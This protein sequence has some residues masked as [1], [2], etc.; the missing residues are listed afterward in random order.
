MER[1][2]DNLLMKKLDA[3]TIQKKGV[4]S[5]VLM[6]RAALAVTEELKKNFILDSVLVVCG[7]GNNGGDGLA[8][9]RLLHLSGISVSVYLAGKKE[10][11]TED[12]KIQWKIA[13]N[14]GVSFVNKLKP[15]EYTTIVDAI[16][17]VGLSREI[18][19]DYLKILQTLET[20]GKPVLAVDIPSGI[21]GSTGQVMGTALHARQ[22]VTFAFPKT[23]LLLYPGADYAGIVTVC[24]IGIYEDPEVLETFSGPA[25]FRLTEEIT[26][27]MP[28]RDPWG[29]KGTFGKVLVVAGSKNM[30]GAAYF[31]GNACLKTGAGMVRIF[32]PQC[33]RIILQQLLPE[34]MLTT[35]EEDDDPG[36]LRCLLQKAEEWADVIVAGPGLGQTP[37]GETLI[38]SLLSGKQ[39]P[40]VL[41]AD[42]LNIL[43]KHPEW[44]NNIQRP[45]ILTPHVGEM[46]RLSG[47]TTAQIKQEPF[48]CLHSFLETYPVTCIL[49]DARTVT[50]TVDGTYYLNTRGNCGM[51]TA[52]SGDVLAGIAGG[53][54]AQGVP[55]ERAA[56]LAVD[57]HARAGDRMAEEKGSFSLTASDLLDG[58]GSVWKDMEKNN[59]GYHEK[60]QQTLC[61]H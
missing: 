28:R 39:K 53:L 47:Y 6:E 8:V 59:G 42:G 14:Y 21:Q 34:A 17:G 56:P 12:T 37:A 23:G 48:Q 9:A 57:L 10:S 31:A 3:Y 35:Y 51:A 32:T 60:T 29:N 5:L 43:A 16:F 44:L 20:S 33:N 26:S 2:V 52:G 54:L 61:S 50:G 58:I 7:S 46:A 22:T 13:E 15:D 25:L 4:P 1:I 55:E 27:W 19:G 49:K 30:A 38:S 45:C 40:L 24:D 18:T 41:D 36:T 11:F